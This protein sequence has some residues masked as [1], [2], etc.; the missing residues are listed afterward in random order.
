MEGLDERLLELARLRDHVQKQNA[1]L[2]NERDGM[3]TEYIAPLDAQIKANSTA[4]AEAEEALR[5]DVLAYMTETGDLHIHPALTFQRRLKVVYDKS[6]LVEALLRE[7][8][9]QY[10]RIDLKAREF[11][12]AF[13]DGEVQWCNAELVPDPVVAIGKLG[14][15][16]IT[17]PERDE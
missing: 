6:E 2:Q 4:L 16:L 7:D 8:Q 14:D 5:K 3:F 1:E 9:R 12:K 11:E 15:M 10:L 17:T 13:R